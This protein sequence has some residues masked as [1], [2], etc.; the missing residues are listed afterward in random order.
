MKKQL[1]VIQINTGKINGNKIIKL[2]TT[3]KG[4]E[5]TDT[6]GV[7][8]LSGNTYYASRKSTDLQVGQEIELETSVLDAAKV[9]DYNGV[10]EN[11]VPFTAKLKWI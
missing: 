2:V 3:D 4:Q 10:D 8:V 5:I 1:K 6:L 9:I 11:N 7:K